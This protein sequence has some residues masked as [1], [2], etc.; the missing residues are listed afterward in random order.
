MR[1]GVVV[2]R[3]HPF[4]EE[5]WLL[6]ANGSMK[7]CQD[8]AVRGRR[9]GVVMSLEFGEKYALVIPEHHQHDFPGQWCHLKLLVHCMEARFASDS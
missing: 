2:H 6:S 5:A 3:Q 8:R 1:A 4:S 7:F 9:N